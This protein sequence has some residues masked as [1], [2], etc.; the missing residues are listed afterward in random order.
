MDHLMVDVGD[1][2]VAAGDVAQLFGDAISAD[3]VAA[4]AQTISYEIL[5]GVGLRVPR[6]YVHNGVS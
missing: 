3:E 2:P 1:H 4:W 6:I 5:C